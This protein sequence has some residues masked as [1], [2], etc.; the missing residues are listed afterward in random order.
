MTPKQARLV[1]YL[2]KVLSD[3]QTELDESNSDEF[4]DAVFDAVVKSV[5][6]NCNI[7]SFKDNIDH[8]DF[9]EKQNYN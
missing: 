7:D 9:L 3:V 8:V 4:D 2:K 1:N 5:Y 6:Y